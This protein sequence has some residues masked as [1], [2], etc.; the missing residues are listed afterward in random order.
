MK[1]NIV[2]FSLYWYISQ[3]LEFLSDVR[4]IKP[5]FKPFQIKVSIDVKLQL[6]GKFNNF[7]KY[8]MIKSPAHV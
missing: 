3:F 6:T 2:S 1:A 7:G 4:M 5:G 8:E